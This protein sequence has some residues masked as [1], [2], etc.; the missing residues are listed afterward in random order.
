MRGRWQWL[1]NLAGC[2]LQNADDV[3]P[4]WQQLALG[5]ELRLHAA[6]AGLKVVALDSGRHFVAATTEGPIQASWLFLVQP[7]SERESRFLSR[8]RVAH[9]KGLRERL[10]FGQTIIEPIGFAMDRRMLLGV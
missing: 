3:H 5:D 1:E 4:D 10:S 2:D 7:I 6:A 9:G 8:Y